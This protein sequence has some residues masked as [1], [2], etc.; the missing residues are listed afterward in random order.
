MK[1][2]RSKILMFGI[3]TMITACGGS[4]STTPAPV[5]TAAVTCPSGFNYNAQTSSC[6][7]IIQSQNNVQT[8][9]A[10]CS[11]SQV[12]NVQYGCIPQGN[13]RPG[14]GQFVGSP[15]LITP[16][17]YYNNGYNSSSGYFEYYSYHSQG[18]AIQCAQASP[19][20]TC[21]P[22]NT[23][24]PLYGCVAQGTCLAGC[25]MIASNS[26]C[27]RVAPQTYPTA[28]TPPNVSNDSC[29]TQGTFNTQ[30]GCLAQE[31]CSPNQVKYNKACYNLYSQGDS[32]WQGG[33]GAGIGFQ[34]HFG[35]GL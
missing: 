18:T 33:L 1:P 25:G 14:Y 28:A 22:G 34:I 32:G 31:D 27:V 9:N 10:V 24:S 13:C 15:P 6:N 7:P 35:L 20:G 19:G 8:A 4:S 12:Y 2:L 5:A 16:T 30:F 23:Y 11:T 21:T 29:C 26:G 3:F 17:P